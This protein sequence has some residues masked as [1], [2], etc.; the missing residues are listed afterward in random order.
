MR[1]S[2]QAVPYRLGIFAPAFRFAIPALLVLSGCQKQETPSTQATQQTP[3]STIRVTPATDGLL[4]QTSTAEFVLFPSGYLKAS[5]AGKRAPSTLDDPATQP[6]QLLTVA[7]HPVSDF[8]LDLARAQVSEAQG[9]LGRAGK[10]IELHASSPSSALDETLLLEF[11]DDFPG[12]AL[13]SASFR[14]T[15]Q[16]DVSLD[17][18]TLQRHRF[19]ATQADAAAA[20]N[21]IRT[22]QGSS[23]KWGKDETFAMPAK[24]SQQN[25]FGAPV[26]TKD[27]L[28]RVGG[29]IPVIAFWTAHIGEAVGHLE[30]VPLVLS[31]P[32]ETTS[33]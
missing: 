28:G 4:V 14:N 16:K 15:G 18:V 5:L 32:V 7:H 6:G 33:D 20:H 21:Q 23:L 26:E 10:R 29:G 27:G 3:V 22:F 19:N 24:F 17:A 13:M 30:T 8:S 25:P 2:R 9:K 12:L 11:Y 1:P 31:I